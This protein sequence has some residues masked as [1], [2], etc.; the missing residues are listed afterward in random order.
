[1]GFVFEDIC[2]QY[3]WKIRIE[4]KCPINFVSLGRWWGSGA[5]SKV[6]EE[7]D[8]VGEENKMTALCGE[9]KWTNEKVSVKGID[10]LI[11]RSKLLKYSNFHYYLFSKVG[12]T[13]DCVKKAQLLD[14]VTLV[15]YEDM[16]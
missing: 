16:F 3:L 14:N 8:I 12:F 11:S 1:M 5:E 9:C 7:I 2:K 15:K 4:E 10:K 13:E 6:Q